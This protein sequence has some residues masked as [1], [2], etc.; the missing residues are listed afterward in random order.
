MLFGIIDRFSQAKV[1]RWIT[2]AK[3]CG[4]GDR[5]AQLR[6]ELATLSV[7][8]SFAVLNIRPFRMSSHFQTPVDP[9][10]FLVSRFYFLL[11]F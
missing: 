5:F 7:L 8:T 11:C 9:L 10:C 3:L 6:P 2:A 1:R 4:D